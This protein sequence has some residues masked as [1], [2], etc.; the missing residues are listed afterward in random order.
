MIVIWGENTVSRVVGKFQVTS[1]DRILRLPPIE[2][3]CGTVTFRYA[4]RVLE[5][6]V[7]A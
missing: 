4:N 1:N 2:M 3:A 7:L 5:V 6:V